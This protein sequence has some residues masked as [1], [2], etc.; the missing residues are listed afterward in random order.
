MKYYLTLLILL[1]VNNC[2]ADIQQKDCEYNPTYCQIIKNSPKIDQ[3]YALELAQHINEAAKE[4]GIK[5]HRLTAI[6]AQESRYK[7][8]AVNYA[9]KD[10][11][12]A[13]INHK[14]IKTF[15]FDKDKLLTD[16]SYSIKAGAIVLSDFKRMYGKKEEDYWTRYNSSDST[17]REQ[18]KQLV[19]RFM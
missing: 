14:T 10:Y 13:Q 7:L 3:G 11:G 12:I 18:Y 16:L 8:D 6:I 9:S 17:K 15:G 4:F 5:P 2:K 1:L 19:M